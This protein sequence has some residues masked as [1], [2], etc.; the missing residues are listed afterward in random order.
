MRG[1]DD[2]GARRLRLRPGGPKNQERCR[3]HTHPQECHRETQWSSCPK[4]LSLTASRRQT[5]TTYC[6]IRLSNRGLGTDVGCTSV[7]L[8]DIKSHMRPGK[9]AKRLV[10]GYLTK[11]SAI[12]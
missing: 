9:G 4:Y 12:S 3:A 10:T 1:D 5:P 2:L 7:R 6:R 8:W 11:R